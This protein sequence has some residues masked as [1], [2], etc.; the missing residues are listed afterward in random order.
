MSN[1]QDT[2]IKFIKRHNLEGKTIIVGFSGGHDSTCLL[3][4]LF[5]IS[6]SPDINPNVKL[7]AAHFNHNWRGEESKMEQENCRKFCE[8][9][10]IEFYTKTASGKLKQSEAVARAIRYEFFN[11]ALKEYKTDVLF[12]AH[13]KN[14]NAETV[15]YR[16]IKGTGVTGLKAIS[17]KRNNIYRPFLNITRE[18]IDE[19]CKENNLIPNNDSSNENVKYKRNFIRHKLMP[20]AK[21]INDN[22][23]EALNNLSKVATD[24]SNIVEE[25]I[26]I[27][28]SRVY[29]ENIILTPRFMILSPSVKRK[30]IYDLVVDNNIDYDS[31]KIYNIYNF[32][33]EN[34]KSNNG[35]KMSLTKEKWIYV[36]SKTI[37]IITKKPKIGN[38][39]LVRLEGEYEFGDYIFEISSYMDEDTTEFPKDSANYAY[40]DLSNI[41]LD[42]VLRTRRDGDIINP[43]GMEGSMKLKKYLISKS[44]PQHRKDELVLLCKENEVLWVAG[45]GLSNKIHVSNKPTH[46]I[47]I[48]HK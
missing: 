15:L 34:H 44:I 28:K 5:N 13:N 20:M 22:V 1:L 3:D 12:T 38:E 24:E 47:S 2:I 29:D 19:Y 32:I 30:L 25:Y 36:S 18:E 33:K 9:R 48:K 8:E 43:L 11:K 27:V 45:L 16:I 7:V 37:E 26:D 35:C 10:Q 46:K 23:V 17:E 42:L 39:V 4:V 21:E 6:K 14:D 41:D 31:E 40:I